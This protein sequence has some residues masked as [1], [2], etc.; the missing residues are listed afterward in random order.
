[1][2]IVTQLIKNQIHTVDVINNIIRNINEKFD[3]KSLKYGEY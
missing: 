1:M 2:R 3:I